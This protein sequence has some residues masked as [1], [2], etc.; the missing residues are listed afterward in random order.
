MCMAATLV[1]I[2][3]HNFLEGLSAFLFL[4]RTC[5]DSLKAPRHP[6]ALN[7]IFRVVT[8]NW[9]KEGY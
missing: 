5:R 7:L 1:I 9:G 4:R 8:C 6:L 2:K 3:C